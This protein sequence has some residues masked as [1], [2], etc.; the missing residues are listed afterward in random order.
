MK[1]DNK[2]E[3]SIDKNLNVFNFQDLPICY[4]T[5]NIEAS[6]KFDSLNENFKNL[7]NKE[8]V[9]ESYF[10]SKNFFLSKNLF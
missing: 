5:E 2:N 10:R 3:I 7:T 6:Y 9:H 8:I 1:F 4:N